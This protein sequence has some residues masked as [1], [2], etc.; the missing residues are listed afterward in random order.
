MP[1]ERFVYMINDSI[2]NDQRIKVPAGRTHAR[3]RMRKNKT[4]QR[5]SALAS[6][7]MAKGR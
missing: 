7:F 6:Q 4:G 5:S 2:E 1:D 3:S